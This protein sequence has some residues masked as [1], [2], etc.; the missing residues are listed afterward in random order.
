MAILPFAPAPFFADKDRAFWRLQFI[1]WG[2]SALLR[3]MT[4]IANG[5]P[6][7]IVLTLI[8]AVTGFSISLILAVVYGRLITK[9][10]L[11]TWSVSA[12]ALAV[13]VVAAATINGWAQSVS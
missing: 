3:A 4:N 7:Q 1:G 11:V 10:P 6:E 12:I 13:A 8:A 9:R 5:K 2:G